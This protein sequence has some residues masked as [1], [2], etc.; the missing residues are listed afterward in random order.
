MTLVGSEIP[1]NAI[2][3]RITTTSTIDKIEVL[4]QNH[5]SVHLCCLVSIVLTI[6]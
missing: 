2:S 3:A 4:V 1:L 5:L 6:F